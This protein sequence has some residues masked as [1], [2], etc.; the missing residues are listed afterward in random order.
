[1]ACRPHARLAALLLAGLLVSL[2]SSAFSAPSPAKR[3]PEDGPPP[4][5]ELRLLPEGGLVAGDRVSFILLPPSGLDTA[6]LELVVTPPGEGAAPLGPVGFGVFGIGGQTRATLQWAWDTAA[7]APGKYRLAFSLGPEGPAWLQWLT[8]RPVETLPVGIRGSSWQS[9][10]TDCCLV[11]FATGTAAQRDLEDLLEVAEAQSASVAGLMDEEFLEPVRLVLLPRVLGHGGFATDEIYISYLD[12]NYAGSDL[13]QVLHHELV[14]ILDARLGGGLRPTMLVEGLAVYL[15]GGHFKPEPLLPRAAALPGLGWYIPLPQ[16]ADRF[17]FHQHEV[18]YL[19]AA[20]LVEYMA[21]RWGYAEF[22]A[23]YRAI[24]PAGDGRSHAEA[25]DAALQSRFSLTLAELDADFR[26][27]LE[28]FEVTPA[29]RDDVRLTVEFFDTV[30][31]YQQALDPNAYFLSAW[32]L[33]IDDMQLEGITADYVRHPSGA[34]NLALEALLFGAEEAIRAGEYEVAEAAI[35]AVNAVLDAAALGA[36]D[37]FAAHPLAADA[38]AI[39]RLLAA[40]G[41]VVERIDFSVG[42]AL[43]HVSR[44]GVSMLPLTQILLLKEGTAWRVMGAN[45]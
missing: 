41:Y 7:L 19:E 27:H 40:Q 1:M 14:H 37:P 26:A 36:A 34:A 35:R 13:A 29:A 17:Y 15:S 21:A 39:V 3:G 2:S 10:Q 45:E 38:L 25:I 31:R 32:L 20:A 24:Q 23:F 4:G 12:R 11:F 28:S 16:L 30:R 42:Q 18:G 44:A 6:G 8:L 5:Y 43:A 9:I 22:N 33:D